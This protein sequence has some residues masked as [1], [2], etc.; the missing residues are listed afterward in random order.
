MREAFRTATAKTGTGAVDFIDAVLSERPDLKGKRQIF[1]GQGQK[2]HVVIIEDEVFKAPRA[3]SGESMDDY[4]TEN[5][6][7]R[8]L[9]GSRITTAIPRIT[10]EGRDFIFFGMTRVPGVSMGSDYDSALTRDQQKQLAR[11]LVNFIVE[12]AQALPPQGGKVAM[13]DDLYYNNIMID[14]ETKRLTGVIDFGLVKY[15]RPSEWKPMYDFKGSGFYDLMQNEFN[16]RKA[17][18][19]GVDAPPSL[20]RRFVSAL[21]VS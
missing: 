18:L 9:E 12:M 10:T 5:K 1:P 14:P 20:F 19:P 6:V 16:A 3:A 17:E 21:G 11:D 4:V 7:L 8:Q 2:G 15:K 13:H